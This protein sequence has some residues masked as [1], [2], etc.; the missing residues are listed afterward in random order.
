MYF[1]LKRCDADTEKRLKIKCAQDL[2]LN[3]DY[4]NLF[5]IGIQVYNVII[6]STSET[7]VVPTFEYNYYSIDLKRRKQQLY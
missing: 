6:D 7:Q 2:E 4:Q 5:Y 1:K 3:D